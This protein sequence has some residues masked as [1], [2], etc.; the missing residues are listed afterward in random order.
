MKDIILYIGLFAIL[1]II[2]IY[3]SALAISY[4]TTFGYAMLTLSIFTLIMA[5]FAIIITKD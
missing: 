1:A 3:I 4:N 5:F 2:L